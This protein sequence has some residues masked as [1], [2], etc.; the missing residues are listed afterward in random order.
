MGMFFVFGTPLIC[1]LLHHQR[2]MA[3]VLRGSA[4]G[5]IDVAQLTAS[6]HQLSQM[7]R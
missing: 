2:K 4:K 3:E 7:V 1:I 5:Q 6:L